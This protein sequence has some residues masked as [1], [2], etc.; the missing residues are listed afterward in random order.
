MNRIAL[1]SAAAM[2]FAIAT[3]ANAAVVLCTGANCVN[4]DENVL[5]T[6]QQFNVPVVNAVTNQT[7]VGVT[8][9]SSTDAL[10]IGDASGQAAVSS[11]DGL[12][13]SLSFSLAS[14]FSF[15]T[16]VFNLFPLSGDQANEATQVVI[17]YFTPGVGS[18]SQVISTNGQNFIGI[19]GTA[20]ERF[21]SAGFVGNPVTSGIGDL[22]QLRLGGVGTPAV[23]EPASWAMMLVGFG[24]LGASMRRR[25]Q[26]VR[27]NFSYA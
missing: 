13:N 24:L 21:I 15:A 27:H 9:N 11:A 20:G 18:Q 6:S 5:V 22:R 23:P 4:T 2:S 26:T 25:K 19:S 1:I 7:N 3:P 17:K 10:L 14:G 16:A 12:L 8:F